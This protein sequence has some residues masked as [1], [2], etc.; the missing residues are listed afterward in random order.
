[1]RRVGLLLASATLALAAC[2][3]LTGASDLEPCATC[4][5]DAALAPDVA[6]DAPVV[7]DDGSTEDALV[8]DD[9]AADAAVDA[10]G[11]AP[12]GC[13]GAPDCD[14]LVFVSSTEL[15][16]NLG[17]VAG[18]D[19]KCQA[20]ADAS[21]LAR[22][23]GHAFRAWVST[24]ASSTSSRFVHGTRPYRRTDLGLVA[25]N[26]N[27][28]V[29][30]VL[31]GGISLDENGANRSGGAWTATTSKDALFSGSSCLDWTTSSFAEK[32][33]TGNVGGNGNG[34]SSSSDVPCAQPARLYC[35]E[36]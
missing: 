13:P 17:G 25:L 16:G 24:A 30:G 18:A 19:A 22:V 35:F 4:E 14:R 28:L 7:R 36:R 27:N 31:P 23:K 26:W 20:L 10:D 1:M 12:G 32:G 8:A 29:A 11:D 5:D 3:A 33:T 2:N 21:T 6:P 15:P 9:S 34:W